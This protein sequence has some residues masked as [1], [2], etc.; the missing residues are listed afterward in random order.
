MILASHQKQGQQ[1]RRGAALV[2]FAMVAPLLFLLVMGSVEFARAFMA[3][4][5]IA[6]AAR[7][8]GR[9]GAIPGTSNAD[10]TASIDQSLGGVGI[11]GYS[12]SVTIN[13]KPVDA[14]AALQG[15]SVEVNVSVPYAAVT[16]LPSPAFLANVTLKETVVMRRE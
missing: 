12:V 9:A 1:I 2:E 10:I 8:G 11:S 5:L 15:D 4:N 6:N 14:K 13:G 7:C 3:N 16:W